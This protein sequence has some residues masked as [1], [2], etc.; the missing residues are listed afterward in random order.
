MTNL[1]VKLEITMKKIYGL[2]VLI[3]I[4]S[5]AISLFG[6]TKTK[7]SQPVYNVKATYNIMVPMR[8]GVRLSADVY[9]P[10][11][12]GKFPALLM[13]TPYDNYDPETG[14]YFASRGYV[15]VLQDVRGK[16]DSEGEFYPF[17][18]E[19]KDGYDTQDW[20]AA[21]PWCNGTI[22]TFGGSYGAATQW[23][24]ALLHNPHVKA[25][26]PYVGAADIFNHWIY[27]NGA[28]VLFFNVIW[29]TASISG[30]A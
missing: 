8:D 1:F 13:R 6:E 20:V 5:G 16:Y 26:F 11:A 3:F 27:N 19:Q 7:L 23:Q 2:I 24:A 29:G 17:I 12:D 9:R 14:Y 25:M 22:G 18:S 21:L 4:C 15:V 10:K 30:Q 28:F